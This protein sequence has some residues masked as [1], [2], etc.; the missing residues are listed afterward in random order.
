M[1]LHEILSSISPELM[2]AQVDDKT[3]DPA[4]EILRLYAML[5]PEINSNY[6]ALIRKY[7]EIRSENNE[8]LTL[9]IQQ[10]RE[11][12][13]TENGCIDWI[14]NNHVKRNGRCGVMGDELFGYALQYYEDYETIRQ[15]GSAPAPTKPKLS[16]DQALAIAKEQ[17]RKREEEAAR[18]A[19]EKKRAKAEKKHNEIYGGM[20]D[21]FSM[22]DAPAE[23]DEDTSTEESDEII[24]PPFYQDDETETEYIPLQDAAEMMEDYD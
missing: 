12:G 2:E 8:H 9:L 6:T 24:V 22:F 16:A 17:Q 7:L 13:A 19:E 10:A 11:N 21:L 15:K 20:G 14:K 18:A 3:I 5:H 4:I 1:K 23:P